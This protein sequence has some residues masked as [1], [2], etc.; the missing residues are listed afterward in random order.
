MAPGKKPGLPDD[1]ITI[2]ALVVFASY[3]DKNW[4]AMLLFMIVIG[5]QMRRWFGRR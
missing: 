1:T 4:L 5:D 3:V 2:I